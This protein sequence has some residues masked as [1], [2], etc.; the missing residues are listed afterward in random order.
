MA[1]W[2]MTLLAALS[3]T[4]IARTSRAA[5]SKAVLVTEASS[6]I[7]LKITERL[8]AEPY[9]YDRAALV[10][11]LDEVLSK[12]RRL[13]IEKVAAMRALRRVPRAAR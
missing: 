11:M 9:T 5:A 8:A 10:K 12:P 13:L 2:L 6:G 3:M 1:R 4:G 7:G